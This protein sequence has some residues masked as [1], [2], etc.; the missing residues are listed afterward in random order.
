MPQMGPM[1]WMMMLMLTVTVMMMFLMKIYFNKN[2][3]MNK[4]TVKKTQMKYWKL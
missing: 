4:N 1:S 2:Y 3:S